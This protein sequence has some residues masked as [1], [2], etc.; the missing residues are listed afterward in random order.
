M[1]TALFTPETARLNG[2]ASGLARRLN[3][4]KRRIRLVQGDENKVQAEAIKRQ[5]R[6]VAEQIAQTREVLNDANYRFCT[7]CERG[8]IEPHHRAQLLRSLDCLLDRQRKLLGIPDPGNLKPQAQAQR[9]PARPEPTPSKPACGP[10]PTTGS[11]QTQAVQPEP[12]QSTQ[13]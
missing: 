3:P 9:R 13:G 6:L 5:L 7:H 10:V 12:P 11:V 8:G 2:I 4:V 1:P